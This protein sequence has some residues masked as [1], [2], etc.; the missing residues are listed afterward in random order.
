M[1]SVR[2]MI[3]LDVMSIKIPKRKDVRRL[4]QKETDFILSDMLVKLRQSSEEG[5]W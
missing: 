1:S 4:M 3:P 2:L 5:D